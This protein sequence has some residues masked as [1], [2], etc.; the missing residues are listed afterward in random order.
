MSLFD[1]QNKDFA[2]EIKVYYK[3]ADIH[4]IKKIVIVEDEKAEK[5]LANEETAK[6]IECLTTKWSGL[7]WKEQTEI[8]QKAFVKNYDGN[9]QFD[10][11][12][13]RDIILKKC[14]KMW[15]ALDSNGKIVPITPES[16]DALPGNVAFALY[17]K[18]EEILNYTE[19]EL[20]N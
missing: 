2:I 7:T 15:D 16:I 20:K 14:L 4:G 3:I 1:I 6:G 12:I 17:N 11:I 13:Y 18:Y 8:S 10:P 19:E 5:L 9:R